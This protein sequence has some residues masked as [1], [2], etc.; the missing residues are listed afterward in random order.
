MNNFNNLLS[1][2][3]KRKSIRGY[4]DKNVEKEKLNY[5]IEAFRQAPSAKNLQPWKLIIVDDKK[6]IKRLV[7]ACK[8]QSFISEAPIVIVA[9]AFEEEAYGVI[10]GYLNSYPLDIG[11]AFEHLVLAATEQGLGTCWIGAFFEEKVKE[12]LGV[13][14][15]VRVVALTPLGYPDD[16][17]RNKTR[18][19]FDEIVSYNKF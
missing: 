7:P 2:I 8:D 4:L 10:G 6:I 13:P 16:D 15:K 11:I 19:T 18:K 17:G 5:L 12:V 1:I 3:S 9:C 14:D